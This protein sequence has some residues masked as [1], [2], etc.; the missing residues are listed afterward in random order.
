M[1]GRAMKRRA[2]NR[3]EFMGGATLAAAG[4]LMTRSVAFAGTAGGPRL[5]V[6]IMR[7]ALDGLAAVP[8]W[9]DPDYARLRGALAIGA[10]GSTDGAL[11]LDGVFGLHPS[12]AFLHE[13]YGAG[14]LVVCHAVASA[15]RERSHFDGQDVLESG[16]T[17]P[18]ASM[19]GWLNRALAALPA[20]TAH[21]AAEPGIAI[22]ANV[23]LLLRG[24]AAVASW[25]PTRLASV[26][27]DTLQRIT[28]LYAQ[29]PQLSKRLAEA[30]TAD[31]M[32][33]DTA[34]V[35]DAQAMGVLSAASASSAPGA[36]APKPVNNAYA[37]VVRAAAGFLNHEDGPRVAVFD[38]TGWDTHQNEGGARGQLANRLGALDAGLRLLKQQ[39]DPVWRSTVVIAITEFG[40][41]AAVNGTGGSDHGTGTVAF[42]MGGAVNGGRV[43]ADWPGL[44]QKALYQQRDLAP[45]LD[46]RALLKGVLADHLGVPQRALDDK[47]FPGSGGVKPLRDL[48]RA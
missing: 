36:P 32:A 3:R 42:L 43:V 16:F 10:P 9:G 44:S 13:A 35:P 2:L 34:M 4:A 12:L 38:T 6:I 20:G 21:S 25:S 11:P 19:S 41:T 17:T 29:D 22:G 24:P 45:T 18:H 26:D 30:L 37:E 15:Y 28:D 48:I 46:L 47:V 5:V 1:K 33:A 31:A 23:P 39:S 8:P 14:E 7:G 40:R 27:E